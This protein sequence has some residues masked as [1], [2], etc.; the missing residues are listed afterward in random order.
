MYIFQALVIC[1]V[2]FIG[3][4]RTHNGFGTVYFTPD[5]HTLTPT[6][7]V[8][9][10]IHLTCMSLDCVGETRAPGGNPRRNE[11][12]LAVR[13]QC[14]PLSN[15]ATNSVHH[16]LSCK[17]SVYCGFS[18]PSSGYFLIRECRAGR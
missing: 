4:V 15:R 3:I 10:P 7:N 17:N 16:Q 12:L 5:A 13:R 2:H 18:L 1:R 9:F 6:H 8:A 11:D 14:Y